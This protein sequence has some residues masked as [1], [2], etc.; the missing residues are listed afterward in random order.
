MDEDKKSERTD[1]FH[2]KD[3]TSFST[4][5]ETETARGLGGNTFTVTSDQF[6]MVVPGDKLYVAM[7]DV[8]N[9]DEIIQ[10]MKQKLREKKNER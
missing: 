10:G 9:A 7:G 1:E 3:V 6:T 5:S 2:Y 8:E 4:N